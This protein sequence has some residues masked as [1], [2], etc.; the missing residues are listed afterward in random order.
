MDQ[1]CC[2]ASARQAANGDTSAPPFEAL[3]VQNAPD[4]VDRGSALVFA[5]HVVHDH[6]AKLLKELQIVRCQAE[7]SLKIQPL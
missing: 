3:L 6:E 1:I 2:Q 7:P 5:E 4:F